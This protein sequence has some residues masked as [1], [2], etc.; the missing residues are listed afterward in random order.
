MDPPV[1][2]EPLPLPAVEEEPEELPA[3]AGS[4]VVDEP[5]AVSVEPPEES[6]EPLADE[7]AEVR[8]SVR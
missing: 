6:V 7:L 1:E 8:E 5:P 4:L 2:E 3:V